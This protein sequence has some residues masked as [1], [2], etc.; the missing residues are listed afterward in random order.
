M[1]IISKY[2]VR[3]FSEVCAYSLAVAM[4]LFLIFDLFE[5]LDTLIKYH[6]TFSAGAQYFLFKLPYLL[7]QMAPIAVLLATCITFANLSR[8]SEIVALRASG[9]SLYH[10]L[11]PIIATTLIISVATFFGNELVSPYANQ[12]VQV[13]LDDIKGQKGK[14]LFKQH[15]IW[16]RGEGVIYN[17]KFFSYQ[18]NTLHGVTLYFL[19]KNFRL[20]KRID[21][22]RGHWD[23]GQWLFTKVTTRTF[24]SNKAI[25][26]VSEE[27][28]RIPFKEGPE[29]FRQEVR[30]PEVM[31]YL[32]LKDYIEKTTNEGYDT[33]SYLADM[34]AKISS[35]FI[36]LIISLLGIPFAIR[37]G[38]HGGFA[39][40]ITLSIIIGFLYWVFFNVCLALGHGGAL[41]PVIAAWIANLIFGALGLYLLLQT[42]H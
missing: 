21:A 5:R 29:T 14:Y 10:L 26:T 17:I 34:Y 27:R 40:G 1:T 33:S 11:S 2:I 42:P 23:N 13:I 15:E 41:P 36:N 4:S 18:D 37:L 30:K 28:K 7:F 9:I 12:K 32:E 19:D 3:E 31:S 8:H 25:T 20:Y 39:L 6:A 22:D 24:E 16:Y 38:R 35:P